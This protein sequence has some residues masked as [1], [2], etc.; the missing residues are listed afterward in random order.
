META[1]LRRADGDVVCSRCR[2]ADSLWSRTWG[3]LGRTR[4]EPDE[5][6]LI[7]PAGAVHTL[8]M[9]FTID[10]VFLDRELTVLSVREAVPP[11]RVV[12]QRGAKA[13]LELPAGGAARTG[14]A[15]GQKLQVA[16]RY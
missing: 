9:R 4:L 14:L 7:R 6:M 1:V 3:L 15:P 10:L 11:W 16:D 2:L 5:G 13:T 8:F 12:A